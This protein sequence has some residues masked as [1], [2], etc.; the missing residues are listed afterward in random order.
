[1]APLIRRAELPAPKVYPKAPTISDVPAMAFPNT[2]GCI[3]TTARTILANAAESSFLLNTTKETIY[4]I[5]AKDPNVKK[6]KAIRL[7]L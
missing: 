6:E 7:D 5:S 4:E 2:R 3:S 1:M